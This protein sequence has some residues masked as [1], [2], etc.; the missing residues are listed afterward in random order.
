VA[1][2]PIS[3]VEAA[4]YR[5]EDGVIYQPAVHI[6]RALDEAAAQLGLPT[7][8]A[9]FVQPDRIRHEEQRY[10]V[11]G[12]PVVEDGVRLMRHRARFDA[13]ALCFEIVILN[14]RLR[15]DTLR[16]LV[17]QAGRY[18][19]I[20]EHRPRCGRFVVTTWEI[21]RTG[22]ASGDRRSGDAALAGGKI[23]ARPS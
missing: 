5:E 18:V 15:E 22:Q 14:G 2:D 7:R 23:S 6:E 21:T 3:E 19:G 16:A 9:L 1:A 8:G 13:W 20:G 4:L 12:R 11:D 17:D 10:V